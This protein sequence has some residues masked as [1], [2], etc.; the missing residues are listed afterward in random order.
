MSLV[1]IRFERATLELPPFGSDMRLL[2]IHGCPMMGVL[3]AL[4][5]PLGTNS[6]RI[7]D[8]M[9]LQIDDFVS[10]V[11]GGGGPQVGPDMATKTIALVERC[12]AAI[13]VQRYPWEERRA[14]PEGMGLPL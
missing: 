14:L 7:Q 2:D 1:R 13:E 10:A 6:A 5:D 3:P 9:A 4:D 11:R 12:A 8:L